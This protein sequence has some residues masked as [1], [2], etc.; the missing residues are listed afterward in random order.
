MTWEINISLTE[1]SCSEEVNTF[2]FRFLKKICIIMRRKA[3]KYIKRGLSYLYMYSLT[4]A[5]FNPVVEIFN[6]K[7][8]DY[9]S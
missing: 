8:E 3:T 9:L 4:N 5:L 1:N 7:R 6:L 2:F